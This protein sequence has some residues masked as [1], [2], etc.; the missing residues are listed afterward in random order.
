MGPGVGLERSCVLGRAELQEAAAG[1]SR[2]L[3]WLARLR[4]IDFAKIFFARRARS[5][6]FAGHQCAQS[7]LLKM[8]ELFSGKALA[9]P[10]RRS[11]KFV[12]TPR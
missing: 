11:G 4:F 8:V 6:I 9:R 7:L 12:S 10:A 1:L 5:R 2:R 3:R